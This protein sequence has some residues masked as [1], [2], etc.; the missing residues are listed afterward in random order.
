MFL[1]LL[2]APW[3]ARLPHGDL[4]GRLS[5]GLVLFGALG[6]AGIRP[7]AL[8]LFAAAA[9]GQESELVIARP[10]GPIVAAVLSLVFLLY[11]FGQLL[12]HVLRERDVSADTIAAAVCSYMLLGAIWANLYDVAAWMIPGAF[13]VPESFRPGEAPALRG[14]LLYFSFTTLTTLGYGDIRPAHAGIAGLAVSEALAGQVYLAV[15]ISRL[16][17]LHLA[18]RNER[19]PGDEP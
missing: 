8:A 13:F 2:L 16:V 5:L 3:L 11:V 15:L 6:V 12:A 18:S 9:L 14:A 17:G 10:L 19:R 1:E 4:W 7:A